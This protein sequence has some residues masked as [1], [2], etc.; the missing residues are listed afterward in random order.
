MVD[1]GLLKILRCPETQQPVS[2]ADAGLVAEL[3]SRVAAGTLKNSGG[4]T[5]AAQLDGALV[6]Q[7]GAVAYPIRNSIP[8]MLVEEAIRL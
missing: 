3:N 6:R 2:E 4:K 8:I 7:D 5:V 1:A